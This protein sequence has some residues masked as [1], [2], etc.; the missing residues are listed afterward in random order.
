MRSYAGYP[1]WSLDKHAL[2]AFCVIDRVPRT[3]SNEELALLK[4]FAEMAGVCVE[5]AEMRRH[6]LSEFFD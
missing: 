6:L 1:L 5:A 2:G 4:E 3:W